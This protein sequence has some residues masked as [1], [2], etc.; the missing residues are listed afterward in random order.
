MSHLDALRHLVESS[1]KTRATVAAEAR[2]PESTHSEVLLGRRRLNSFW[3]EP[4]LRLQFLPK[5]N[6]ERIVDPEKFDGDAAG[7]CS[8]D[9][10]GPFPP[11]MP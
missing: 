9:Q 6:P 5:F 1:G 8:T 2:L 4:T 10:D 7:W 11:E 3:I